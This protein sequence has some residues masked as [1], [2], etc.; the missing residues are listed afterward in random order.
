MRVLLFWMLMAAPSLAQVPEGPVEACLSQK[1]AEAKQDDMPDYAACIGVAS[2]PC[3]D[4]PEGSTTVGMSACL[5]Q[6][7]DVWDGLLNASYGRVMTAAKATDAEM[8]ELGSATEP[9]EPLL[10]QMQR[11]W[12]TFRDAACAYERSRWGGG[13]G[14]G[15]A[16][17]NC[18]M[19]LTAQQYLWLRGYEPQAEE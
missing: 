12:I 5:K 2:G 8:A 6:E 17:A 3:M 16:S 10:K 7:Y 15:P 19:H 18:M 14:S 11:D 4:S 9:Q 1:Q 13:T